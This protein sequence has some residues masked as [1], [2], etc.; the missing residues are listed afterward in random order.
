M[1]PFGI[2]KNPLLQ[3]LL[4]TTVHKAMGRPRLNNKNKDNL[5]KLVVIHRKPN[6]N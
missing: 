2:Y 1:P 5:Y 4:D 6:V 3:R